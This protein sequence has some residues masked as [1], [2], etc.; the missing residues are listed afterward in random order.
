M[1]LSIKCN[2]CSFAELWSFP[3]VFPYGLIVVY[4]D[5]PNLAEKN[6]ANDISDRFPLYVMFTI[7][8]PG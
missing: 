7:S 3:F 1:P 4:G 8:V 6:P 2:F 5:R